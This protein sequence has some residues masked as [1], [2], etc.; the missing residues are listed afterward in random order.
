MADLDRVRRWANAL[1]TLH[2][3]PAVWSFDFDNA[4]T[5]AGLC[6]YTA[7]RITVSR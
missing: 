1:I 7:K 6:N 3:D 2:L 4:K 5:R